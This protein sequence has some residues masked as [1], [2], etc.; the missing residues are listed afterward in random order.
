MSKIDIIEDC[1]DCSKLR[2]GGRQWFCSTTGNV[3]YVKNGI[4][5]SCRLSDFTEPGVEA[6]AATQCRCDS[7]LFGVALP[8]RCLRC[9]RSRRTA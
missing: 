5:F 7:P 8:D 1:I 3:V 9:G 4:P 6:D 2:Y